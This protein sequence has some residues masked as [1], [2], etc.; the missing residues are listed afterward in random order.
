MCVDNLY[1]PT[2]ADQLPKG[3]L[4]LRQQ[5]TSRITVLD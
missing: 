3:D 4:G 1:I 5:I 2:D